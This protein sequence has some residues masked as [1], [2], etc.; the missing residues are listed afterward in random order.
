MIGTGQY[1]P[2]LQDIQS[3]FMRTP[4]A[5]QL[6]PPLPLDELLLQDQSLLFPQQGQGLLVLF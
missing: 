4:V 3:P 5:S 2:G 1:I 6:L